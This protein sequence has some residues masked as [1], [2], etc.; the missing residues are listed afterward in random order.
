MDQEEE[1]LPVASK[2]SCV[3]GSS[4]SSRPVCV[5]VCVILRTVLQFCVGQLVRVF[6]PKVSSE[7]CIPQAVADLLSSPV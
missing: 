4:E 3:S 5:C 6:K 2:G 1:F 7:L